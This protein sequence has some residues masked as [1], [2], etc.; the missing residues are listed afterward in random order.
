[1]SFLTAASDR[2]SNGLSGELS[3][4]PSLSDTLSFCGVTLGL[5]A[6]NLHLAPSP[7]RD[8]DPAP[9]R[10]RRERRQ[11]KEDAEPYKAQRCNEQFRYDCVAGH[12]GFEPANSSAR[13]HTPSG[14]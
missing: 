1:M 14:T 10:R 9:I 12:L 8:R 4:P 3:D 2:S 7:R 11:P 13:A 5:L 6:M